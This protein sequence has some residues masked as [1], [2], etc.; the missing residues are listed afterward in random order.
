MTAEGPIRITQPTLDVLEALL[1]ADGFE[2]HGWTII[3][4]TKRA[5]PTVYKI[6]ERLK[7]AGWVTARW[8]EPGPEETRP[9]RRYYRLTHTGLERAR[10]LVAERRPQ[11]ARRLRPA[12]GCG[13]AV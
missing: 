5:G 3:K 13:G 1:G 7:D 4:V 11:A 6:L 8:E 12:F 10:I 9:R 2:L